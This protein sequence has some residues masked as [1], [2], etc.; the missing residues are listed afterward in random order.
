MAAGW[1]DRRF[2]ATP[3]SS[4]AAGTAYGNYHYTT[5]TSAYAYT[6]QSSSSP[7]FSY[8]ENAQYHERG[9][10]YGYAA[11]QQQST[12][13]RW[14]RK[15]QQ[16]HVPSARQTPD[17][18]DSRTLSG[19][20]SQ[21]QTPEERYYAHVAQLAAVVFDSV[22]RT[23]GEGGKASQPPTS[24][25]L[26]SF[27]HELLLSSKPTPLASVLAALYYVEKLRKAH[28]G[29][30]GKDGFES[31]VLTCALVLAT[32]F[33]SEDTNNDPAPK[34]STETQ[35]GVLMDSS[36]A[37]LSDE[38]DCTCKFCSERRSPRAEEEVAL[39]SYRPVRFMG[40]SGDFE[41]EKQTSWNGY[42]Y[43]SNNSYY[44]P[45]RR[46]VWEMAAAA[47]A[48]NPESDTSSSSEQGE[49]QP[50]RRSNAYWARRS[51]IPL[52]DLTTMESEF[53]AG[54]G[55]K[56]C[57][58]RYE[59]LEWLDRVEDILRG[60][61]RMGLKNG[62]QLLGIVRDVREKVVGE[63]RRD[64]G[65]GSASLAAFSS[66]GSALSQGTPTLKAPSPLGPRRPA[67]DFPLHLIE[68]SM[69]PE[70]ISS[71]ATVYTPTDE[72]PPRRKW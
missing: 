16:Q 24:P 9:Y 41:N 52:R 48:E 12:A 63:M 25:S 11:K 29:A 40:G 69:T 47:A 43:G 62:R 60:S 20:D 27:L 37:S 42:C 10:G 34:D 72:V 5:S 15:Q 38:D 23:F 61:I 28:P 65:S 68:R 50:G 54:L 8:Y 55:F 71:D 36:D 31:S 66:Q 4:P 6:Q 19:G 30:R 64:S 67:D 21:Q 35:F 53:L 59:F 13:S 70:S 57:I 46:G 1:S 33:W 49:W 3:S 45:E 7:A 58:D 26:K 17:L 22:W 14:A 2:V 56:L 32:K 39:D 51:G 18:S 44:E